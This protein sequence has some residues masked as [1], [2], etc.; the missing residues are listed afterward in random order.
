MEEIRIIWRSEDAVRRC[1]FSLPVADMAEA[2]R[3]FADLC[4]L[5]RAIQ[6]QDFRK[7][8]QGIGT[9]ENKDLKKILD[10]ARKEDKKS[11][12]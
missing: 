12:V 4:E 9:I 11:T 8:T 1:E 2:S 7:I 3:L 10:F 6:I 5:L